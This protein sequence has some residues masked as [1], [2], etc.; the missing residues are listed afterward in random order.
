MPLFKKKTPPPILYDPAAQEPAVRSSICTGEMVA[1]FIDRK[2]GKFRE[3][4]L[5]RSQ[6]DIDAFCARA[7]IEAK[8]VKRIY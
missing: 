4:E 5:V 8:D 6:S 2:T 3:Y 1:G 7:G